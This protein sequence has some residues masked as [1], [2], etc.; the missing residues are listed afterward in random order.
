MR[1]LSPCALP[2]H[3]IKALVKLKT[4]VSLIPRLAASIGGRQ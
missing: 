2:A 4:K 1:T 3:H